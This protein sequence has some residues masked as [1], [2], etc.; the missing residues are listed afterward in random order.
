MDDALY[1]LFWAVLAA[2]FLWRLFRTR[3]RQLVISVDSKDYAAEIGDD[4]Q[5]EWIFQ[6]GAISKFKG[7]SIK[8]DKALPHMYLDSHHDSKFN[9]PRFYIPLK[10]KV[11]LEGDFDSY[12]QLYAANGYKQLALSII[13]PDVMQTLIDSASKYDVEIIRKTIRIISQKNVYNKPKAEQ[14]LLDA[15]GP[16]LREIEQRMKSWNDHDYEKI[17]ASKMKVEYESTGKIGKYQI[18]FAWLICAVIG[19]MISTTFLIVTSASGSSD[20]QQHMSPGRRATGVIIC[21]L[22]PFILLQILEFINDKYPK[23]FQS[24]FRFFFE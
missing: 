18:R 16:L 8:L 10:N 21:L 6:S 15:A 13:S 7:I 9:G 20:G 23:Q 11:S 14:R 1:L 4:L 12:F 24:F 17:K 3:S 2:I 5:A 22:F 19:L